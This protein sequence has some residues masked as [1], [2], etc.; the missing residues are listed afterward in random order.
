MLRGFTGKESDEHLLQA[1]DQLALQ[2]LLQ[3]AVHAADLAARLAGE[4]HLWLV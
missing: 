4:N 3:A 2:L 1:D